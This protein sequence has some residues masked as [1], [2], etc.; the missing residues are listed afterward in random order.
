MRG[1]KRCR[2]GLVADPKKLCAVEGCKALTTHCYRRN[3]NKNT[4][5]EITSVYGVVVLRKLRTCSRRNF[6]KCTHLCGRPDQD[7]F[8]MDGAS[9]GSIV[10]GAWQ[11]TPRRSRDTYIS[12]I[13]SSAS[14]ATVPPRL[15][16]DDRKPV[17]IA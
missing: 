9:H 7:V 6:S 16:R 15:K 2:R 12:D 1:R 13:P 4:R 10:A 8:R 5:K 11:P 17:K 3:D 14:K